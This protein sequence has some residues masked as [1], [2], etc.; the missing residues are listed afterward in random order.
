[1]LFLEGMTL[2]VIGALVAGRVS[3]AIVLPS[4]IKRKDDIQSQRD[5]KSREGFLTSLLKKKTGLRILTVGL[6]LVTAAVIIGETMRP[7]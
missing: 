2:S 7:R 1:M 5:I 4:F 6:I 3:G